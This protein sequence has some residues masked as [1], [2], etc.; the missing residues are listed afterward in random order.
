VAGWEDIKEAGVQCC[1]GYCRFESSWE[2]FW[3]RQRS[4]GWQR[5]WNSWHERLCCLYFLSF[6][7]ALAKRR[8]VTVSY[9]TSVRPSVGVE[10]LTFQWTDFHY[11]WCLNIL[12]KSVEKIQVLLKSDTN[13]WYLTWRLCACMVSVWLLLRMRNGANRENQNTHLLFNN[14]F[15]PKSCRLWDCIDIYG[16]AVEVTDDNIIQLLRFECRITKAVHAR[17][18]KICNTNCFLTETM[19]T[20]TRLIVTLHVHCLSCLSFVFSFFFF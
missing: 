5:W 10:H 15:L 11:I 20:R 3:T 18:Q 4:R 8:K 7:G 14:S 12:R 13:D 1:V 6:L 9:V 2:F 17:T 19:V 16:R